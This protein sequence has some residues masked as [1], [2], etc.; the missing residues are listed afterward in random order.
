MRRL[1][2]TLIALGVGLLLL[3]WGLAALERLVAT[4]RDEA[5]AQLQASRQM[6][7]EYARRALQAELAEALHSVSAEVDAAAA[8]PLLPADHLV[9]FDA[10]VQVLPRPVSYRP[11]HEMPARA[12]Y[13]ALRGQAKPT[14]PADVEAP[15]AERRSLHIAVHNA[16]VAGDADAVAT[17]VRAILAH[18]AHWVLPS[19]QDIPAMVAMLDDLYALANPQPSLVAGLLREGMT[20]AGGANRQGLQRALLSRRERFTEADFGFLAGRIAAL[21]ARAAVAA[22]DFQREASAQSVPR[23]LAAPTTDPALLS[24]GRYYVEPRPATSA[25][26]V[27]IDFPRLLATVEAQMHGHALLHDGDALRVGELGPVTPMAAVAIEVIAPRLAQAAAAADERFNVKTTVVGLVMV[28]ALTIAVLSVVVQRNSVRFVA[29]KSEFVAAVSH[30]L[31]T[32][33]TS[34]RLMAETVQRR[35]EGDVRVRD[36][37][38]RIVREV[39]ALSLLVDNILSFSRLD[40]GRWAARTSHVPVAEVVDEILGSLEDGARALAVSTE[41]VSG[42][43]L[44]MDREL[45]KLVLRN[46]VDNACAYNERSPVRLAFDAA[47][48]RYGCTL[49]VRDNGIG[50]APAL[51]RHVF[52]DFRRGET[53]GTRGSGLGL[54]ICR[55]AVEAHGGRIQIARSDETGTTFE[56]T[57]PAAIVVSR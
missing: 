29:L 37:P 36:Y 22:A 38:A 7:A 25:A 44:D 16:L 2:P 53:H 28:L 13:L 3:L 27:A 9:L 33:L 24:A 54:S 5:K 1:L 56:I 55:K 49:R 32:P 20:D 11:G 31:R 23:A 4:E 41:G 17:G 46:L 10:G 42:L 57:L 12:L 15:W 21:A 51:Q 39:D 34:I 8:D 30:E 35:T 14:G 52:D 6:L 47:V 26:G 43:V 19:G 50:I 48:D 18:R 40:K 45:L